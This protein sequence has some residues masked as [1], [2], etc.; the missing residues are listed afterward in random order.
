MF[1]EGT[2]LRSHGDFS[3]P[4]QHLAGDFARVLTARLIELGWLECSGNRALRV[5]HVGETELR[6]SWSLKSRRFRL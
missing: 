6:S 2:R 1:A 3:E 4:G 5:T